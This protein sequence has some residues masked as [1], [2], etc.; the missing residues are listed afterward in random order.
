MVSCALCSRTFA[1][2]FIRNGGNAIELKNLLGHADMGTVLI[3][4][5]LAA[6]DLEVAQQRASVADRWKL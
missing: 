1:V 4:V 5:R 2:N 3:Y 6:A